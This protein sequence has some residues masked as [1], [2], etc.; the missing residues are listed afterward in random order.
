[1][2]IELVAIKQDATRTRGDAGIALTMNDEVVARLIALI[3]AKDI[4]EVVGALF[5]EADD[6]LL[7]V[8]MQYG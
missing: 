5:R 3:V 2:T 7:E 6:A 1:M 4:G 8:G